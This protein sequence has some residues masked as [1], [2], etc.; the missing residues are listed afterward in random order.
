MMSQPYLKSQDQ[1]SKDTIIPNTIVKPFTLSFD[2]MSQAGLL[3]DQYWLSDKQLLESLGSFPDYFSRDYSTDVVSHY[4][5]KR[6]IPMPDV[7]TQQ[8][9]KLEKRCFMGIFPEIER[10]WLTIDHRLYM[11]HYESED[12]I[13]Y[14]RFN[15]IITSVA[16][17]RP[18]PGVFIERVAYLLVVATT[19]DITILGLLYKSSSDFTIIETGMTISSDQVG[20]LSITG[21][22]DGRIILSG[23]DGNLYELAYH[24]EDTWFRKKCRKLNHTSSYLSYFVPTFLNF[25][26]QDPILSIIYD[27]KRN[28]LYSL[29]N[30][31]TISL[32]DL[33]FDS[34]RYICRMNHVYQD[35]LKL[36]PQSI[37]FKKE[38]FSLIS[39][40]PLTRSPVYHLM[41]ITSTGIRLYWELI[42]HTPESRPTDCQ[43]VHVRLPY[44]SMSPTASTFSFGLGPLNLHSV[45]SNSGSLL[46]AHAATE[47]EDIIW[48]LDENVFSRLPMTIAVSNQSETHGT[49]CIKGKTWAIHEVDHPITYDICVPKDMKRSVQEDIWNIMDEWGTLNEYFDQHLLPNRQFLILSNRGIHVITKNRPM[50]ILQQLVIESNG[51]IEHPNIQRFFIDIWKRD[52]A[53]AIAIMLLCSKKQQSSYSHL[54][55][56]ILTSLLKYSNTLSGDQ[57][58]GIHH[59]LYM[60]FSR[61]VRRLW[62]APVSLLLDTKRKFAVIELVHQVRNH[63]DS[64]SFFIEKHKNGTWSDLS[65]MERKNISK[66]HCLIQYMMNGLTL[67][68]MMMDQPMDDLIKRFSTSLQTMFHE[69]TFSSLFTTQKGYDIFSECISS[70][71]QRSLT[72]TG[73]DSNA[74]IQ[75]FLQR[76]PLFF[77]NGDLEY[78]RAMELVYKAQNVNVMER[79]DLVHESFKRLSSIKLLGIARLSHICEAYRQLYYHPFGVILCIKRLESGQDVDFVIQ[80][81]FALL[82]DAH[83][84]MIHPVE[85]NTRS[86]FDQ[87]I[88]ESLKCRLEEFHTRLYE[89]LI[90][91]GWL[92][93]IIRIP[94]NQYIETF[95][96]EYHKRTMAHSDVLWKYYVC[97][98]RYMEACQVLLELASNESGRATTFS[99]RLEFLSLALTNA[100]SIS[101]TDTKLSVQDMD[102]LRD[103]EEK[104]EVASI[105]GDVIHLLESKDPVKYQKEIRSL[106]TGLLSL[107]DLYNQFTHPLGLWELSLRILDSSQ[108]SDKGLIISLWNN[109]IQGEL[110]SASDPGAAMSMIKLKLQQLSKQLSMDTA[111]PSDYLC[112]YLERLCYQHALEKGWV[113]NTMRQCQVPFL[114]IFESLHKGLF[115]GSIPPW[116]LPSGLCFLLEDIYLVLKQWL[117]E[118]RIR[119]IEHSKNI[120]QAIAKYQ[121]TLGQIDPSNRLMNLFKDIQKSLKR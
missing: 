8:F 100:K 27:K 22:I 52:H 74:L 23:T 116:T 61:I 81:I 78:F 80:V 31:G 46:A 2:E 49:L 115:E 83:Y 76:C 75:I 48:E 6:F 65:S 12:F 33:S 103:L 7:L 88:A 24:S 91:Q 20:I 68:L 53:C 102:I 16:L 109:I 119:I 34:V 39:I 26:S 42:F 113:M 63:L 110:I 18:R 82:D 58:S 38:D 79:K 43:L 45:Y 30:Q 32:F 11:W 47:E 36:C 1:P 101:S 114:V 120:S 85:P 107:S 84:L 95:L 60:F 29:S 117:T 96:T 59:G 97:H 71:I 106:N 54:T 86:L 99:Q 5:K 89:W 66:L 13:H 44:A 121:V 112:Q 15:Q 10:V 64:L 19:L 57:S 94:P 28:L 51:H 93:Y 92:E 77:D 37:L 62:K 90:H 104:V 14:D 9:E 40:H 69:L 111:F 87:S 3:V 118:D 72:S 25:S 73:T 70:L 98:S 56:W 55:N 35:F 50:D 67:L 105:Q 21:T 17:V 108:Y 41:A 4:T